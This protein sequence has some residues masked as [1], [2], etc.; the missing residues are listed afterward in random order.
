M[1]SVC[2]STELEQPPKTYLLV[3]LPDVTEHKADPVVDHTIEQAVADRWNKEVLHAC[4]GQQ[5]VEDA[6]AVVASGCDLQGA[7]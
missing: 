1:F 3:L 7:M 2:V 6:E 4:V 5:L